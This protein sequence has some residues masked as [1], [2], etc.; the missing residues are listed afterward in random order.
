MK[1]KVKAKIP[2]SLIYEIKD[3]KPIYYK[4]YDKVLQGEKHIEEVMGS[5]FIQSFIISVIVEY[6][7]EKLDKK[8]YTVLFD[9]IG[10]SFNKSK[11]SLDI[12]IYSNKDLKTINVRNTYIKIAPKVVIEV[13]TKADLKRYSN[14]FDFYVREKTQDLLDAG[15]E[16]VIWFSSYDK[17]VLIAQK[18][19]DWIIKPW[20]K[21][22][23]IVDNI[24]LNLENLI[25]N[26]K[27]VI[28]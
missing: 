13:D 20:N 12:A 24:R 14:S 10:F 21:E 19:K 16:K 22:V 1:A 23:E 26:K 15:V 7:F 5:S 18:S 25:K 11:R 28:D 9:E 27:E 6:L 2:T 17:K 4:D 3:G 8:K